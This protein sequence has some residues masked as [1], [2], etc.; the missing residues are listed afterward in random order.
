MFRRLVVEEWWEP[1]KCS[2]TETETERDC[3]DPETGSWSKGSDTVL[4]ILWIPRAAR[5]T[6]WFMVGLRDSPPFSRALCRI[7]MII[8][9]HLFMILPKLLWQKV[10][11]LY[12]NGFKWWTLL[13][14]KW[15]PEFVKMLVTD[16]C[17]QFHDCTAKRKNQ[18][19][20]KQT[21][22]IRNMP[23]VTSGHCIETS[24]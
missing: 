8:I 14:G 21:Q 4:G 12:Q 6:I 10:I 5:G 19:E 23:S 1:V 18:L 22:L 9:K 7:L 17:W 11:I 13:Q 24:T 16:Y 2:E 15:K 20:V 3:C